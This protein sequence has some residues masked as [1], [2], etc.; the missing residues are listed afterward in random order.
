[1]EKGLESS[2]L[3]GD[4]GKLQ[5]CGSQI[6][7]V[8]NRSSATFFSPQLRNRFGCPQYCGVADLNCGCPSL[9]I[10][11]VT[12]TNIYD[13]DHLVHIGHLKAVATGV[14]VLLDGVQ[15]ALQYGA[16][17]GGE[18]SL[19]LLGDILHTSAAASNII[20]K[21]TE[22]DTAPPVPVRKS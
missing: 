5:N 16:L 3:A 20:I 6:L 2:G 18:A 7:K 17:L 14:E 13:R 4:W 1:V 9:V 8:R 12:Q 11:T 15:G 21:K 19:S 22:L 10:N